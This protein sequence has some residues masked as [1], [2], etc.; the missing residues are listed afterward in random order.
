MFVSVFS[1]STDMVDSAC[2]NNSVVSTARL[3]DVMVC[4][5]E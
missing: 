5:S 3:M 1:F 4:T 2:T